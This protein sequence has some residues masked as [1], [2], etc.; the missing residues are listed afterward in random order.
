MKQ[1]KT[2]SGLLSSK[3][4]M[5]IREEETFAEKRTFPFT[6]S[7]VI[8][9]GGGVFILLLGICFLLMTTVL[10]RWFD[11]RFTYRKTDLKLIEL[12]V[13]VDSLE[14]AVKDKDQYILNIQSILNG[15]MDEV[16]N[17]DEEAAVA[18]VPTQGSQDLGEITAFDSAFRKQFEGEESAQGQSVKGN[19]HLLEQMFFFPPIK[20]VVSRGFN[21]REKHYGIDLVAKANEPI[22]AVADGIVVISSWTQDSGYVIGIQHKNQLISFYKH[23]STLLKKVG[24]NV[25]AGDI[26]AIIGNSGEITDGPHLHFEMWYKQTPVDPANFMLFE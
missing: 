12:G 22:K 17:A 23:N 14:Q 13:Q 26:I 7:K 11:P 8:L 20:G 18:K 5:V 1:K 10:E 21:H 6:F 3:F 4:I 2:L 9:L 15:T 24:D 16:L 19:K 25:H